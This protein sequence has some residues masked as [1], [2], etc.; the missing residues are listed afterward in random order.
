MENRLTDGYRCVRKKRRT[1]RTIA[2]PCAPATIQQNSTRG[3]FTRPSKCFW[4][5]RITLTY[6]IIN[7]QFL[8]PYVHWNIRIYHEQRL[9]RKNFCQLRKLEFMRPFK[10]SFQDTSSRSKWRTAI[11]PWT[12]GHDVER[13]WWRASWRTLP[14]ALQPGF[15]S[16]S[17][18]TSGSRNEHRAKW[19][20]FF[21]FIGIRLKTIH[22]HVSIFACQSVLISDYIVAFRGISLYY[23]LL[24]F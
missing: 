4:N 15:L 17:I 20:L 3:Q 11:A 21:S 8:S 7:S 9:S 16:I 22:E 5:T 18:L 6:S 24:S 1:T 12:I 14:H 13:K 19:L 10:L 2:S 23:V